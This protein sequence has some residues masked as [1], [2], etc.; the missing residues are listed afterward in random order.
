MHRSM[1][2]GAPFTAQGRDGRGL[3]PYAAGRHGC[4]R[5]AR[6]RIARAAVA[7]ALALAAAPSL[8]GCAG[9]WLAVGQN[10]IDR[11]LPNPVVTMYARTPQP[12]EFVDSYADATGAG[13]NY[14]YRVDAVTEAGDHRELQLIYFGSQPDGEGFLAIDAKG[15][16]GVRYRSVDEGELPAEALDALGDTSG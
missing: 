5:V 3:A 11:V 9:G 1:S 10:V 6:A 14:V 4:R 2:N 7:C 16:S 15:G 8:S 13:T 12:E